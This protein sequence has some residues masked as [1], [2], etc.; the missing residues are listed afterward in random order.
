MA[1]AARHQHIAL[2]PAIR[3]GKP[4]VKLKN[5]RAVGELATQ[6][7]EIC[8]RLMF[9][10]VCRILPDE[11]TNSPQIFYQLISERKIDPPPQKTNILGCCDVVGVFHLNLTAKAKIHRLTKGFCGLR[12]RTENGDKYWI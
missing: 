12:L 1:S 3:D 7:S 2:S 4:D 11:R 9:G 10:W 5:I 8:W 6:G